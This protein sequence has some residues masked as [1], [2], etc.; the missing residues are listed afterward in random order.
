[1]EKI[2]KSAS[3]ETGVFLVNLGEDDWLVRFKGSGV[4]DGILDLRE[5]S[6]EFG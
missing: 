2:V 4:S 5:S 3:L 6:S 1:M